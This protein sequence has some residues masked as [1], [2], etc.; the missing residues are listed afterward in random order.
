MEETI[1]THRRQYERKEQAGQP[2][3]FIRVSEW[4]RVAIGKWAQGQ[5]PESKYA[6]DQCV[7]AVLD[8]FYGRWRSVRQPAMVK[9]GTKTGGVTAVGMI[10]PA[11][12]TI[13]VRAFDLGGRE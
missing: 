10:N 11:L 12:T 3:Y 9:W 4:A 2:T 1:G 7:R 5:D 6:A 8:Y 13:C